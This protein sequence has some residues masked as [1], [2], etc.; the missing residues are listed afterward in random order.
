MP[1]SAADGPAVRPYPLQ[2]FQF[3]RS[4]VG[5][6]RWARRTLMAHSEKRPHP[7]PHSAADGPAVRPY[8]LLSKSFTSLV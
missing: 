7:T 5:R 2:R 8:L 6:D 1:H 3:F 4:K